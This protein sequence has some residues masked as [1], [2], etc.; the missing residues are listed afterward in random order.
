M[1]YQSKWHL[2]VSKHLSPLL[3]ENNPLRLHGI[4]QLPEAISYTPFH[5]IPH[6]SPVR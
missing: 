2:E 5:L 3:T 6:D 1:L 4:L